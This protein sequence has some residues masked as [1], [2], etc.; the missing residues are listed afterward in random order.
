MP[1]NENFESRRRSRRDFLGKV[2]TAT[3]SEAVAPMGLLAASQSAPW[4]A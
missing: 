4:M 2:G 1:I 3:A